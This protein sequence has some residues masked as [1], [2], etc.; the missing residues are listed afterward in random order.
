VLVTAMGVGVSNVIIATFRQSYCPAGMIGR[1]TATMRFVAFGA[2][3]VGALV[4][5]ALGTALGIRSAMW[6]M[7][8]VLVLSGT[9]LLTPALTRN[10][11]LPG[12][13]MAAGPAQ[14]A[15]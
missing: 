13:R 3:P 10:R 4:A 8:S 12:G 14:V 11:S 7:L 6:V 1:V 5:G 15:A 9:V 2:T